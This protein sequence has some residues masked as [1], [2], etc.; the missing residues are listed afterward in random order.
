[1]TTLRN[2]HLRSDGSMIETGDKDVPAK[3]FLNWV[4]P[5]FVEQPET[6]GAWPAACCLSCHAR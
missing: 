3:A 5:I 4:A 6:D 1:M 2:R